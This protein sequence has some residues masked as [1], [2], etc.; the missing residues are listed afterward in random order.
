MRL[1]DNLKDLKIGQKVAWRVIYSPINTIDTNEWI[2]I[3]QVK[4]LRKRT[5]YPKNRTGIVY[6][7]EE[8]INFDVLGYNKSNLLANTFLLDIN[9]DNNEMETGYDYNK[10]FWEVWLIECEKDYNEVLK[11]LLV[12]SL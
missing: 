2:C 8:R 5:A 12:N 11:H 1:L 7:S 3:T 4:G 6:V 9:E 10:T